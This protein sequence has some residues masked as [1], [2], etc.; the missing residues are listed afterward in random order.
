MGV[1]TELLSKCWIILNR[2]RGA[3][4]NK[5]F[6][7]E[8]AEKNPTKVNLIRTELGRS[9]DINLNSSEPIDKISV[10]AIFRTQST[11]GYQ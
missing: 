7:A 2:L 4:C 5:G 8:N 11:L 9:Q 6:N 3:D 1:F 10:M